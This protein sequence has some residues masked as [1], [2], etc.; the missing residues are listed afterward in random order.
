LRASGDGRATSCIIGGARSEII[1]VNGYDTL[2]EG[3]GIQA[4][5]TQLVVRDNANELGNT[6]PG[7]SECSSPDSC[8]ICV[9]S[10]IIVTPSATPATGAEEHDQNDAS[11]KL[12]RQPI[13]IAIVMPLLFLLLVR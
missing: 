2:I 1:T 11:R 9:C 3:P 13:D 6:N 8:R 10:L 12:E 5:K 4:Q 7:L